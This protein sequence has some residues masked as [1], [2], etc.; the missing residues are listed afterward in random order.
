M[1]FELRPEAWKARSDVTFTR[2]KRGRR[3]RGRKA[4][5]RVKALEEKAWA[6]GGGVWQASWRRQN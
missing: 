4:R 6:W 1:T 2:R 5:Q 3:A